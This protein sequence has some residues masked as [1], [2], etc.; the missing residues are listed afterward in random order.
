[1]LNKRSCRG[2]TY[3]AAENVKKGVGSGSEGVG[4]ARGRRGPRRVRSEVGPQRLG[5]VKDKHA[6]EGH[7][8][9]RDVRQVR[10]A[11]TTTL[12][13]PLFDLPKSIGAVCRDSKRLLDPR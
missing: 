13:L 1:M 6:V 9:C 7:L 12:P 8:S 10:A 5:R 11:A 3:V 4:C 2:R